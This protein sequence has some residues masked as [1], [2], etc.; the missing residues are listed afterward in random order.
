MKT[1]TYKTMYLE[2]LSADHLVSSQLP[3]ELKIIEC[4]E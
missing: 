2:M 1:N 3:Q 4:E